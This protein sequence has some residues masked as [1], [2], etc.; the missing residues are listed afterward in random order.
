MFTIRFQTTVFRPDLQVTLRNDIDGWGHDVPGIYQKDEW[1]F[2][3]PEARYSKGMEFKFVLERMY[4]MVGANLS[5][6]PV[7]GGD[8]VFSAPG[9]QFPPIN[10]A[11]VENSYFQQLFFQPNLDENHVFEVI[12]IGSGMG[13]GI[14]AEQLADLGQT[15]W[16]LRARADVFCLETER[17]VGRDYV[18]QYR[19]QALQLTAQARF[20]LAP[21]SRV[22]V[23]ETADG[24]LRVLQVRPRGHPRE[25][26]WQAAPPRLP[27]PPA[28]P[29]P[30]PLAPVR[31][32]P[33]DHP[34]RRQFTAW[35]Q[36]QTEHQRM[37]AAGHP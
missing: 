10:E 35:A 13:G 18:I 7:A 4:W 1:R 31:P 29:P 20:R 19:G 30:R 2:D 5:L 3:L 34:W 27:K 11:I 36:A 28:V 14:V 22:I 12:V 16:S 15:Y 8:Y 33:A 32:A 26:Q 17:V 24:I 25:V 9:A 37:V 6:L 23:R 21:H